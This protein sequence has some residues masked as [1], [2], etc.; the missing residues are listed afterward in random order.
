MTTFNNRNNGNAACAARK[1]GLFTGAGLSVFAV[2][3]ATSASHAHENEVS[4]KETA[5][6][7]CIV[8]NGLPDH[9][10]GSF[11]NRGNP[12]RISEQSVRLCVT[13]NPKKSNRAKQV[14]GSIGVALNGVQIRPGTADWYDPNSRR[15]HSRDRS[16]GWNLEGLGAA[17]KLGMD[18]NNAHVDQRGL[19]HYH[20]VSSALKRQGQGSLI[21]YAADGFEIHYVGKKKTSSYQLRKGTRPSGPG[22]R[23]DGTY[24]EDWQYVAGSGSLDRCNGGTLNGRF[25]YFATDKYPFFPRCLWGTASRDFLHG[26]AAG[27][28][29]GDQPPLGQFSGPGRPGT[30]D[31]GQARR[32]SSNQRQ[33]FGGQQQ[34]QNRRMARGPQSG[35]R[36]GPP[37]EA[38][39]ACQGK[40]VGATCRM[41]TPRGRLSGS[42]IETPD[43]Q[44][45]CLPAGH[46]PRH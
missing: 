36:F 26:R 20:G 37:P 31:Q 22:G 6:Q 3:A 19:Y 4:I 17:E 40:N 9:S 35:N 25:V 1:R 44:T 10:T 39:K 28:G 12:H 27:R 29:Q 18:R 8:S 24:V 38:L 16:S 11:P 33:Q 42:C 45:A 34:G 43:R 14:R 23:H 5:S 7:R 21:G 13:K 30:S 2:L 41:Q 46:R 15:G 32:G